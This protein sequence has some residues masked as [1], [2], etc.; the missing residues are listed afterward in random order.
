MVEGTGNI[1]V[2]VVPKRRSQFV[3]FLVRLVKQKPLATFG[4]IIVI[5]MFLTGI[6]ANFIA[7]HDIYEMN[8]GARLSPPS[9]TYLL[10]TDNIGRDLFS[11]IVF[12]ARISMIVGLCGAA[13]DGLM[14]IC[15]GLSSG[16]LG[17]KVDMVLQR[18]VDAWMSFPWLFFVLSV[19]A[20]L[21]PGILQVILVLGLLR[22]IRNSRLVRSAV[23]GTK[24]NAYAEAAVAIGCPTG[25]ILLR[26]I[27]PNITA[28]IIIIFTL[29]VGDM[30][31]AE[32]TLSFL[33]F[34]VPPPIPSWG[35]MLSVEGRKY[36]YDAPWLAIW[37]GLA[38]SL[39]VFGI[40]MLGD[41][42]RDMLDPRLR[43][44]LGRYGRVKRRAGN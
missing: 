10:G 25:K 34:G 19:M 43:G 31:L 2:V 30:I 13:L 5:L 16:F 44:S 33:G 24:V 18:F 32:A 6:F 41:G 40:N 15:I 3:N 36:M 11:R 14:S 28:P 42:V 9:S 37:P 27:L 22:G 38:L 12:G 39:V 4:G 1:A 17:G 20:V 7:P 21:G 29:S 26:H 8:L 35:Q 23:I